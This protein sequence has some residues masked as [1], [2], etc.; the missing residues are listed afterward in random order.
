MRPTAIR[1][2]E[3]PAVNLATRESL[4]GKESESSSLPPL[5]RVPVRPSLAPL[6]AAAPLPPLSSAT[7]AAP[8]SA[9][10]TE[11]PSAAIPER[12]IAKPV[13][14]PAASAPERPPAKPIER[15]TPEPATRNPRQVTPKA[16]PT[17]NDWGMAP[18]QRRSGL[19]SFV[20][21]AVVLLGLAAGGYYGYTEYYQPTKS[22]S[23]PEG[24]SLAETDSDLAPPSNDEPAGESDDPFN[25]S[26]PPPAK[27][28]KSGSTPR[29]VRHTNDAIPIENG[30]KQTSGKRTGKAHPLKDEEEPTLELP[31][32]VED[33]AEESSVAETKDSTDDDPPPLLRV[34][35][36]ASEM[37]ALNS[38]DQGRKVRQGT[39]G[40]EEDPLGEYTLADERAEEKPS[41]AGRKPRLTP[42]EGHDDHSSGDPLGD[43]EPEEGNRRRAYAKTEIVRPASTPPVTQPEADDEDFVTDTT[44]NPSNASG[45]RVDRSDP[46]APTSI[47][48]RGF[49]PNKAGAPPREL[50]PAPSAAPRSETYTA[51]PGD[52]FWTISRK[53]YGSGRYF[54]ALARHNQERIPDPQRLRPG[55]QVATPS[56]AQLEQQYP[57]LI[58]K[59]GAASTPT[60]APTTSHATP[61]D[62]RPRFGAPAST[63]VTAEKPVAGQ[64]TGYFYSKAGE[65]MYRIGPDDTLSSIAQRHLGRS[66]R[67]TEI[68]EQNQEILN[69]PENL[70]L[71]KVIRLPQDASRVGLAPELER[72]R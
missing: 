44:R 5:E 47:Q 3:L 70:P 37:R 2:P 38:K 58:D 25:D 17:S 72:R 16:A 56:A 41:S 68:Y 18:A 28:K 59:S 8:V 9:K 23:K 69:N 34:P 51:V 31:L 32:D 35:N 22:D 67:W 40:T 46:G 55:M 42:V 10:V 52:N 11:R 61:N 7:A 48:P 15:P 62:N 29:L 33:P 20:V 27:S 1:P 24:D 65:P 26:P 57:E 66:A 12:P 50:R 71:G 54:A 60:P 14:R 64:S 4:S 63:P 45:N 53:Q 49:S 39:A 36:Q 6:P 19:T 43:F 30:A 13:T 21:A